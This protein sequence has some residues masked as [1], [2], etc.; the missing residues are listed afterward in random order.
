MCKSFKPHLVKLKQELEGKVNVACISRSSEYIRITY[1]VSYYPVVFYI[2]N[3]VAYEMP[4]NN[5]TVDGVMHFIE[6]GK[7]KTSRNIFPVKKI[8]GEMTL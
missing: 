4:G 6:S 3:G 1:N 8:I 7:Y 2:E 5:R